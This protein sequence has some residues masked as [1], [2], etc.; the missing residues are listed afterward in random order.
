[1][2][3]VLSLPCFMHIWMPSSLEIKPELS[4]P[5]QAGLQAQ[6]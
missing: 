3:L 2:G 5:L 1:M 6:H 4:P